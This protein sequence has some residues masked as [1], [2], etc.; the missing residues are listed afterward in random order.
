MG[1]SKAK[2]LKRE[3]QE[4]HFKFGQTHVDYKTHTNAT[5]IEHELPKYDSEI[6]KEKKAA[7]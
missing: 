5:L 6:A 3:L 7:L 2:D 1:N 4:A